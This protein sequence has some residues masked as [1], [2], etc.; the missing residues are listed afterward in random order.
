MAAL[1]KI[2]STNIARKKAGSLLLRP[3][4]FIVLPLALVLGAFLFI[5]QHW[6]NSLFA[7]IETSQRQ[8]L[9]QLVT[10]ARQA[11]EPTLIELRAGKISLSEARG[12]VR[13][14]VRRMTYS[15]S[16]GSN[17]VFMSTYD[18]TMLVQPFE[19]Q[20]E[21]V[22]QWNLMDAKGRFIIRELV[23]AAQNFPSGSFVAYDYRLPGVH[24]TQE[25][26]TYVVGIPEL[27][28][29]LGT[30]MYMQRA[31]QEERQTLK[32]INYGSLW[33][34]VAV[35]FPITLSVYLMYK[36]SRRALVEIEARAEIAEEL[37]R[38]E[39]R[40]RTFFEN[41]AEGIFQSFTE[42]GFFSVNP[43]LAAMAGYSSPR[44]MID[45]IS[46]IRTQLFCSPD[47]HARFH[48]M[49]GGR[50]R[51]E[52]F[53]S[54]F[55]RKDGAVFW[56]STSARL[57]RDENGKVEFCEGLV[58]D[59]SKRKQAEDLLRHSEEKLSKIFMM[60]PD[61]IAITQ[62][63]DG[64]VL[65][66]NKGFS[67]ITGW[68]RGEILG[69]SVHDIGFWSDLAAR[70]VMVSELKNGSDVLGNEFVFKRKDGA[71]RIGLYSARPLEIAGEQC[72]IFVLQD[73][74]N[75]RRM[76]EEHRRLEQQLYQSQKMDAIGQL[77]S[78]VAHDF[79]NIL[80]GIQGNIS[81]LRMDAPAGD[82]NKES[83]DS[84]EEQVKRG[85]H[86]TK[87]L[88]GFAREGKYEPKVLS[89]NELVRKSTEFFIET[90]KQI[91]AEFHLQDD[92]YAIEADARQLEQVLLNLFINASH[93]MPNGGNLTINTSNLL[94]NQEEASRYEIKPGNYVRIS[95]SDTGIGMDRDTLE[96]IFEP[97]F[98]TKQKS[99]GSGLGLAS[100]YGII[101]N[102]GGAINAYSEV[103][104][105]STFNI[106]LPS[107]DKS[108]EKDEPPP[109]ASPQH[110][111][112]G[113]LLVDDESMIVDTGAIMLKRLGYTV[114]K[115]N[116]GAEAVE[117]YRLHKDEIDLVL[118]DMIMPGMN[119]AQTLD[120]L[121]RM[122]PC[123]KVILSSGYSLQGD[124][125]KVME[126]GCLGFIQKPYTIG[127]LS[128]LVFETL[129]SHLQ[130]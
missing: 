8:E 107:T 10:I 15:D 41:T 6:V 25:K 94:L 38:S 98:T 123:V 125:Q 109:V 86:L 112:G 99:G 12:I 9:V 85:A 63:K 71:E 19:P 55:K 35:V 14:T 16:Y 127:E 76:E 64:L 58:V 40:Y 88:L 52:N 104:K 4:L 95:V 47:E 106:Y 51:V 7:Q 126:M 66:I 77:A 21:L 44:D 117:A 75:N 122:N 56:A 115:A 96:R 105:G 50:G 120:A 110:G 26:L 3:V 2:I 17:Y 69:R 81:L 130:A 80:M 42:G 108:L 59:I 67:Q 103:E 57:S 83:L 20:M 23:K 118:L 128:K 78:G 79:N 129:G 68:G 33:L 89:V 13:S 61:G 34:L 45:S 29:Y 70:D 93:A 37:R 90:N 53:V 82:A 5:S 36:R 114:I 102:H 1:P 28:C 73:T 31:L 100:A 22:N 18:G 48:F 121:M 74:T 119:G 49:L 113:I 60:M 30:G 39:A 72:L 97:F 87:Q 65:E 11:V 46:D 92:L 24:S 32:K 91:V 27:G 124:V 62:M 101:R 43:S 84:V 116:N 54:R 111:K